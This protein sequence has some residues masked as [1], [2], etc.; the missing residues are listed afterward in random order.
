M[1]IIYAVAAGFLGTIAC[2]STGSMAQLARSADVT[3][4]KPLGETAVDVDST[5]SETERTAALRRR[6]TQAGATHVV[7]EGSTTGRVKGQMYMC[8]DTTTEPVHDTGGGRFGS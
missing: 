2:D 3:G 7:S 5:R 1:N 8:T 6:A 4:C